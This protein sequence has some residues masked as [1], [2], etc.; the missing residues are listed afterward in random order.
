MQEWFLCWLDEQYPDDADAGKYNQQYDEPTD[1]EARR[2][3]FLIRA[4]EALRYAVYDGPPDAELAKAS[5]RTAETWMGL[6]TKLE[7]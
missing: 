2:T 5:Y 4:G 1:E 7:G 3:A 6:A